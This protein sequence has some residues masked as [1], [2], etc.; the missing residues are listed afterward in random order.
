MKKSTIPALAVLA[1]AILAA[2]GSQTFLGP[3][4]HEDGSFGA[5]HWAGRAL[6]GEGCLL[7]AVSAF[8]IMMKSERPGLYLAAG[9]GAMLGFFT[10]DALIAL[11]QS[12]AMRCRMVMLPAAR[13]LFGLML[14]ASVIGWLMA[15]NEAR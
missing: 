1:L 8:A 9:L 7:A 14:L 10:P 15:R 6:M 3:C 12:P 13:V 11:C 2:I 4:V 5:C